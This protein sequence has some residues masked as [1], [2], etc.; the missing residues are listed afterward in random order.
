MTSRL[1]G[2]AEGVP[3]LHQSGRTEF[4]INHD[5]I[6]KSD[7]IFLVEGPFDCMTLDKEGIPCI[8]LLG[9]HRLSRRVIRDIY[10][11]NVYIAFDADPNKTGEKAAGKIARKLA[12]NGIQTKIVKLPKRD[13]KLDINDFF[14]DNTKKD[15]MNIVKKAQLYN[16]AQKKQKFAHTI[17]GKHDIL[18][19]AER[20]M[21]VKRFGTKYKAVCPFHEDS[22]P[23]LVFYPET[24]TAYCFGCGTFVNSVTLIKRMEEIKGNH[25]T[26]KQAQIKAENI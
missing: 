16:E 8:G 23:S 11:K 2:K 15:F 17:N 7:N 14:R 19:I 13:I 6:E 22:A 10:F 12:T 4:A 25:I 20:Y 21:E 3:H 1:F 24:Q 5:V 26:I 18:R 9:A